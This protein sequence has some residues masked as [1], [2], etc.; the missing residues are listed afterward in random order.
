MQTVPAFR[1]PKDIAFHNLLI[2]TVDSVRNNHFVNL[3]IG[4]KQH[5]LMTGPTGTGKTL[6]IMNEINANYYNAEFTNL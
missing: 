6:N 5:L 2:P 1:I 3:Y 4:L